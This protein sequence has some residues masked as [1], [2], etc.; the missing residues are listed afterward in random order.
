MLLNYN[1]Y[2]GR[3][4]SDSVWVYEA[5]FRFIFIKSH[6]CTMI[7]FYKVLLRHNHILLLYL[8]VL[9]E[10]EKKK[11]GQSNH[12]FPIWFA[13]ETKKKKR[14]LCILYVTNQMLKKQPNSDKSQT[15]REWKDEMGQELLC[16]MRLNISWK[17]MLFDFIFGFSDFHIHPSFNRKKKKIKKEIYIQF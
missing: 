1:I 7:F 16:E 2:I 17:S 3:F 8:Q 13:Y 12:I 5:C 9:I 14:Q 10:F 6:L 15:V 4:W 11:K